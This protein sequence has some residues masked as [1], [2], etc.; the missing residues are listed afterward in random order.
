MPDGV[1]HLQAHV[2]TVVGV[3]G[4]RHWQPRDAVIAV[5]QDLDAHALVVLEV[6]TQHDLVNVASHSY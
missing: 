5:T 6:N 1:Y 4:S 3:V 2:D